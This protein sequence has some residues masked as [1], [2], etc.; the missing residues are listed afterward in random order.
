MRDLGL[1]RSL[2]CSLLSDVMDRADWRAEIDDLFESDRP[3]AEVLEEVMRLSARLVLQQF[4]GPIRMM[5]SRHHDVSGA[6]AD[7]T[8]SAHRVDA[9]S[10]K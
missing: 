3:I 10:K 2:S 1:Q 4:L 9:S 6:G 8:R 7:R 5:S